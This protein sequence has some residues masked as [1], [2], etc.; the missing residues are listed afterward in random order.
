M[1]YLV[2]D[3]NLTDGYFDVGFGLGSKLAHGFNPFHAIERSRED[4]WVGNFEGVAASVTGKTGTAAQ[5]FRVLP[6]HLE[7]L[8]HLDVY[9][10]ANNHAMQHG[11]EA[12]KQT[13]ET[14]KGLGSKVFGAKE[15]RTITIEHQRRNICLTGFSQRID[16]WCDQPEYWHNPEYKE[17]RSEVLAC[18]TDSYKIAFAHWGNEFINY[19]SSQQKRFAHWLIDIGYDLVVGMHPHILQGYEI[20]NNK[21][22][23]Y[24]LGN[25]VF[26]MPWEP[27]KY[28]AIVTVDFTGDT[29]PDI[30]YRYVRIGKDYAP[31]VIND[32]DVP[33]V[34]RF[35]H[36]NTL[37]SKEENSEEY[38]AAI[39]KY[40]KRYRKANHID[41]AKKMLAHPSCG[42][43]IIKDFIKRRL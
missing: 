21:Y 28:G 31:T 2:G 10:L 20:Y 12:Y 43:S 35:E 23:F 18:P 1:I 41:I 13:I 6:N 24:S 32:N 40:Y 9:G 34:L 11:A 38:H 29:R 26:D 8:H 19:P 5:Q 37:I 27:T 25:F 36:L 16:T 33:D 7:H 3:I 42:Y 4:I 14:L 22:I 30:K 17:L 15:S 39:Q